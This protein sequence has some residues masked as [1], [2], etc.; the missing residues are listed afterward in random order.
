MIHPRYRANASWI[1]CWPSRIIT[2]HLSEH[3]KHDS[4]F[5][6]RRAILNLLDDVDMNLFYSA[7]NIARDIHARQSRRGF[8]YDKVIKKHSIDKNKPYSTHVEWLTELVLFFNQ[9]KDVEAKLS[10]RVLV[11]AALFHDVFEDAEYT[12]QIQIVLDFLKKDLSTDESL[13]VLRILLAVTKPVKHTPEL[14]NLLGNNWFNVNVLG[15]EPQD[16]SHFSLVIAELMFSD[17]LGNLEFI[18][19]AWTQWTLPEHRI[20]FLAPR[21]DAVIRFVLKNK[22]KEDSVPCLLVRYWVSDNIIQQ[23]YRLVQHYLY[24]NFK[25]KEWEMI[26][27]SPIKKRIIEDLSAIIQIISFSESA[28]RSPGFSDIKKGVILIKLCDQ[29][30]NTWDNYYLTDAD[31][32][33]KLKK[34]LDKAKLLAVRA[35]MYEKVLLQEIGMNSPLHKIFAHVREN[36]VRIITDA[37]QRI[38]LAESSPSP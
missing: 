26:D 18:K 24:I 25:T 22:L 33:P 28:E 10:T 15:S 27:I 13:S 36:L 6:H 31:I 8:F 37:H 35:T 7:Q 20:P 16:I 34:D 12:S 1:F 19:T 3:W 5:L 29:L 32:S 30:Y 38:T 21:D 2:T 17:I 23:L 14:Y 4:T 11:I 9:A